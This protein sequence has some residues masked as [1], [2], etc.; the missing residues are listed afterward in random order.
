MTRI[1]RTL[2]RV[3]G[4]PRAFR[5]IY[6]EKI[7]EILI[8]KVG[9]EVQGNLKDGSVLEEVKDVASILKYLC[10][11]F[12]D[13]F[14]SAT[15]NESLLLLFR[16]LWIIIVVLLISKYDHTVP[17]EWYRILKSVADASPAILMTRD[18]RNLEADLMSNSF[19]SKIP[20]PVFIRCL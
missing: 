15:M 12:E 8:E 7:I 4:R 5:G 10:D 1:S 3:R 14:D 13:A 19:M 6:L 2:A 11:Q 18:K 17:E 16:D 9:A 20:D